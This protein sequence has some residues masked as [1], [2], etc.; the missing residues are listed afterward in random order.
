VVMNGNRFKKARKYGSNL[1]RVWH[2]GIGPGYLGEDSRDFKK[3]YNGRLK[4]KRNLIE[5]LIGK[6]DPAEVFNYAFGM[7]KVKFGWEYEIKIKEHKTK[8]VI[9]FRRYLP[10]IFPLFGNDFD[11]TE[12]WNDPGDYKFV[13]DENGME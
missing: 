12:G 1:C 7:I 8:F 9:H 11:P 10:A 3:R 6:D 13:G 5:R 4:I 2:R